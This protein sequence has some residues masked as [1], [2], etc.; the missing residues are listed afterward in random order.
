MSVADLLEAVDG[1]DVAALVLLYICPLP[2][3]LLI[4]ASRASGCS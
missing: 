1:G 3:T 4:I 2:L